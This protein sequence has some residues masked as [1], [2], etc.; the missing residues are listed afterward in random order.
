MRRAGFWLRWSGRDLR[1]RW[2]LVVAIGLVIA[3]GT[4][5]YTGVG[6]MET[7]RERSNDASYARLR[8]HDVKVTLPA[9]G[10]TRTGTLRAAVLNAPSGSHV[11]RA[12]ERLVVPT[13]VEAS[14]AGRR[15]LTPGRVVGIDA[16][17]SGSA[18]DGVAIDRGR[19][20]RAAD[21]RRPVAVL[22]RSYAKYYG[23]PTTGALRLPG[24]RRLRY[25]GQ[26]RSPEYFVVTAPGGGGFGAAEAELAVLFTPL[27][28]AQRIVG[29]PQAVN[30]L[31]LRLHAGSDAATVAASLE[32]ELH[33]R[34]PRL[35]A[36]AET[37]ADDP[38]HRVLYKDAEG[39]Q[40]IFN[41]FALL[42]LAGAAFAA[43]NL[44]TRIVESQ[45]REI[46]VG[47]A[48]GVSPGRLALR[49][50]LLGMEI[51]L[52]GTVMGVGIGLWA[53]SL[54]R[55]VLQDLLPLPVI[56]TPFEP[57]VFLRG[58]ALGFALPVLAV[59]WPVWRGLRVSPIEAIRVGFRSARGHGMAHAGRH[60]PVPGRTL[61]RMPLRNALRAP[62]RTLT[63]ALG[64]AAVVAVLVG[65]LGMIDSFLATSD[66]S[67]AE[68][69]GAHPDRLV[70]SLDGFR[71]AA[72][73]ARRASAS[74]AVGAVEPHAL[75]PGRLGAGGS[76]FVVSLDLLDA[77]S[78]V[79]RPTAS[80]G[81]LRRGSA[82]IAISTKAA[83]DLGVSPGEFVQ[84]RAARR[85]GPA[86]FRTVRLHVRVVA[87]HRNP[88]RNFA[89]MDRSQAGRF[90][91]AGQAD[92]LDA[93][94]AP[95]ATPGEAERALVAVPGVTSVQ[96]AT[97][98]TDLLRERMEDFVGVFRT[99]EAFALVLALLIAFNSSSINADERARETATMFAFGVRVRRAV[100]MSMIESLFVGL[101]GTAVGVGLG[102]AL[103]GWVVHSIVPDTLPDLGTIVALS[104]G[105]VL[106]AALIGVGAVAFAPVLTV[107]RLRRMRIPDTL[108]VVE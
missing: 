77:A 47:M 18:I 100:G 93:L 90:G 29:R 21:A 86:A 58:A 10:F 55:G 94:P 52:L 36:T 14:R 92:A 65:L 103:V 12:A 98:G 20:L 108:R 38:A 54:F 62:R 50:L 2:P 4:G 85:V 69:A 43:F 63:T 74:E 83:N 104:P 17:V 75:L 84:L 23:L 101:L 8:A 82:G 78:P 31:V 87:V 44:S 32:R 39:D 107:R 34:H 9:G 30:D 27:A 71:P 61:G 3:I 26:G 60:V 53:G 42:I 59:L 28:E 51:A 96:R 97:A 49:P 106:A 24:G 64:I 99:I 57:H 37:L 48:L 80:R 81:A 95:G 6:S 91:V 56:V 22:E 76:A 16:G 33:A 70:A 1:R 11:A 15:I 73:A 5:L 46:G 72:P 40:R 25:V 68:T 66:R 45:R 41:V 105:S 35:G 7:W 89:Y 13:Q 102:M 79:W 88:F 67:A 19:G